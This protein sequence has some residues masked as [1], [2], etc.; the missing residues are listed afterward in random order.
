MQ[1]QL[2]TLFTFYWHGGPEAQANH[3]KKIIMKMKVKKLGD[4]G[5]KQVFYLPSHSQISL[6]ILL[7]VC[8]TILMMLVQRV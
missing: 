2:C 4:H 3:I 6:V 1:E 8:H 5:S 7:T